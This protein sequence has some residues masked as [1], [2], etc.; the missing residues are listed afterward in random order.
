[1]K[2][3]AA[4]TGKEFT[5]FIRTYKLLILSLVF[6][7][8]GM[9]SPLAAK[10]LPELIGQF[11]PEG[12]QMTLAEPT[13]TDAWMQ[14]HKNVSQMGTVIT[15]ILFSGLM[16]GEYAKGTLIHI[17]TKGLPRR[18]VVLAKFTASAVLFTGAYLLCFGTAYGYTWFYWRADV[19]VQGLFEMASAMWLFGVLLI[20]VTLLGGIILKSSYG[21]L[22]FT[23]GAVVLQFFLNMLP[24]AKEYNPMQLV[25]G[26][27]QLIQGQ[28]EAGSLHIPMAAA[29]ACSVACIAAA[30]AV[31][32]KKKL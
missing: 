11:M 15:V 2:A 29:A 32:N 21:A 17:L 22:L 19:N 9:L 25:S 20:S 28:L 3:Y 31:F 4:F 23:G 14:F 7:L 18:T 27:S 16:S 24:A 1:M 13:A 26:G 6:L 5:E 8:F 30:C 12:I 10:Y